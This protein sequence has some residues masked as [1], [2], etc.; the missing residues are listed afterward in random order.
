MRKSMQSLATLVVLIGLLVSLLS[1]GSAVSASAEPNALPAVAAERLEI[2]H[3]RAM[4]DPLAGMPDL[5]PDLTLETPPA[6]GRSY[7]LVQFRG[8]IQ[9]EWRSEL[10]RAGA[11]I[12]D[13]LPEFTYV[14]GMDR[15]AAARVEALDAV[16]WIGLYQPAF[17]LSTALDSVIAAAGGDTQI[18]VRAFP[19]E[20]ADTIAVGLKAAGGELQAVGQDSGGGTLFKLEIPAADIPGVARLSS[21]AWI[22]PWAEPELYNEIT[23]SSL[24]FGKDQVE[25]D[26]GLYGTGQVV[27]VGDTGVSTG[28]TATM[29]ADFQGHFYKGS[30]GGGTC[31][32]WID[33]YSHGTHVAGSVLGNGVMDGS[34]PGTH[35]YAGTNAGIAPEAQLWAWAFCSDWSGLPEVDPYNDYYGTM[36]NDSSLVRINT[37]SWGYDS[38]AGTYNSFS[39]ETDR[40]I[41]DHQDMLVFFSAGNDGVDANANGIVDNGSMGVPAGSKNIVTVGASENY[42]LTGGYNPGGPC[43][44]WGTCWPSD[45][46]ANPVK[47][48]PLSN[49]VSGM[50]AFSSR[51][52]VLDGRLKPDIV[53]P[54]SNIVSTRYQGGSADPLWGVYN[55]WYSY[56]GGTSMATPLAAGAGA[57]VREFYDT[58]YG[59]EPSAALAKATLINGARDM[60]PGQYRDEVPDGSKDDVL[61]RPD[62]NQGWGRIDLAGTLIYEMPHTFWFDDNAAGLLTGGEYSTHFTISSDNHPFRV[63]LA[64]PDYPGTEASY[65]ALVNDLDLEVIGP[66]GI[67]Y[68]GNDRMGDGLLDGD[69]DHVNNVEGID[70]LPTPG[71]YTVYVRGYNVP[72]GPQPFALVVTGDMGTVGHLN[73]TVSDGTLGGGL[74][75]AAVVAITGT[76]QFDTLTQASGTYSMPLLADTYSVSAWKYGYT[77]QTVTGVEVPSDSVKTQDFTLTQTD[78]HSLSGCVTDQDTGAPLAADV[79]VLGPFGD[80]VAQQ[81]TSQATGCYDLSLYGGPYTVRAKARLHLPASAAVN[82]VA[83]TVQDLAL[84]ATTTDGILWGQVTNLATGD[85][86]AG[87][88]VAVMP[89]PTTAQSDDGG[90][91]ELQVP[92]GTYTVTV[93]APLYSTV[94]ETGVVVP[95]SNLVQRDYALPTAH[96]DL[97]PPDG[98][99]VSLRAGQQV[100]ET[101][102][103]SNSGQ[104]ALEWELSESSVGFTPAAAGEDVLV[105]DRLSPAAADAIEAALVALGHS[106]REVDET[107]FQAVPVDDLL[108]YDLLIWMGSTGL[109][110]PDNANESHIMAY[111]DAGGS[112]LHTD[113][114]LGYYRYDSTYFQDYL[115]AIYGL[116]DATNG[117]VSPQLI[118][119]LDL[120]APLVVDLTTEPYPDGIAP[121]DG[122]AT[123]LFVALSPA[124]PTYPW[125]G[126]AVQGSAYRA[127]YLAFDFNYVAGSEVQQDIVE[128]AYDWLSLADVPWLATDIVSGT[129]A[130]GDSMP[131]AV[132]FQ[133]GLMAE[134]GIYQ[135]RLRIK[136]NDPQAQ[137][138]VDYAIEMNLL[139]PLPELSIAKTAPAAEAEVG[140]PLI[141]TLTVTNDGGLATGVAISDSVPADTTFA[142]AGGGGLLAGGD[143]VWSGL[144]LPASSTLSVSYAVTVS[145]V[146]SGTVIVNDDYQVVAA[147]WPTPT[148]GAPLALTAVANGPHAAMDYGPQ[149]ALVGRPVSWANLSTNTTHYDWDLGDG[150]TS[151]E[152][153]PVHT[154]VGDPAVYTVVLTSSNACQQDVATQQVP[155]ENYALALDPAAQAQT[156]DA[157][158]VVT[159]ALWVTNT[160]TLPANVSLHLLGTSWPTELSTD[161]LA[162]SAGQAWP[163][164]VTVT[165]PAGASG[166]TSDD[167]VLVA[168]ALSDPRQPPASAQASLSTVARPIYS[169]QLALDSAAEVAASPGE[170]AT[171]ALRVTNTSNIVDTI[172]LSRLEPGWP[173]TF[174]TSSQA[175]APGGWRTVYVY[176]TVPADAGTTPDVAVIRATGSGGHLDV[177]LTTTRAGYVVYLPL[178]SHA[179]TGR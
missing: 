4:F 160:G 2:R 80:P 99:Q 121:R 70:L 61:R 59:L 68:K 9:S 103:V 78:L 153:E 108:D 12:V 166:G 29:H 159:Y 67:S 24:I 6:I 145:C 144:T 141:Y 138:R 84:Q 129:V 114:D 132:T 116:D 23:R 55:S 41:W 170:T 46:S 91:Y 92:P 118:E 27:V 171:Y 30:T 21:V 73:G 147:E 39:R 104:G 136:S 72:Q 106:Y 168:T 38:P 56:C 20:P 69:V 64:W 109:S 77:L 96:M 176:I 143:M 63:T 19:G 117:A 150:S 50:V 133:P 128:R 97:D 86:V 102:A 94:Q 14:A 60:T 49:D 28:N 167:I 74:E 36:Y 169:L 135:A 31:T 165:L 119:G 81:T 161:A 126:L 111:L 113:N 127:V 3:Q 125:V 10:E 76:L 124:N 110:G 155:V 154:Y 174:S 75:A 149:P 178:V 120:M 13:Y 32:S 112:I 122:Q 43:S 105:V 90:N 17:R 5:S 130:P 25:A 100:V 175:I 134:P 163:L 1:A 131:V 26:L 16:R 54:G 177:T 15:Q 8:P 11:T 48:D 148:L 87:A 40:F 123:P 71:T 164:V 89:G 47:D 79:T 7:Y 93:S 33:Y 172:T 157:G 173:T 107:T 44:T 152:V 140:M 53:A 146:P 115:H 58:T 137:P 22:E 158:Q 82:L 151:T 142:W 156:A 179:T 95:Q 51:G 34:V 66:G 83:D 162:L 35:S 57:I 52:P 101:L 139:P 98:I 45:F 42:R 18:L 37:N 65:G 88:T 85:P 62:N